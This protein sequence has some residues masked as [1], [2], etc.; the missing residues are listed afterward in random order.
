MKNKRSKSKIK[1]ATTKTNKKF[2]RKKN[3]KN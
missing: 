2:L 3:K 1:T